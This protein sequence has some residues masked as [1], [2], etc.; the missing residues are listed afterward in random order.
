MSQPIHPMTIHYKFLSAIL[1][2]FT[3]TLFIP[4]AEVL[5]VIALA[6]LFLYVVLNKSV[7]SEF[8]W[9]S[10]PVFF[11]L[12]LAFPAWLLISYILSDNQSDGIRFLEKRIPLLIF[13]LSLGLLTFPKQYLSRILLAVASIVTLACLGALLASLIQYRQTG[14]SAYLYN[15]SLSIH[16]GQQSIYTSL[17]VNCSI[18]IFSW[19]FFFLHP[20][21]RWKGWLGAGIVFLLGI[22]YLLASRNM[23]LMLY[24]SIVL[25]VGYYIVQRRKYLEGITLLLGLLMGAFMIYKF[26]PK[27]LNR[28]REL[29]V[30]SYNYENNA[31]E[32]HYAGRFSAEQ[33]NGANFRLAAWPCGWQLVK[34]HPLMGT[35]IGDKR[36]ELNRVYLQRG[37]RFAIETRKNVHNNYLD[38]LYSTGPIGLLLFL[39]GWCILPLLYFWRRRQ[40]V[41]VFIQSTLILAM[42]TEVYFDRSIG[43]LAL[44]FLTCLLLA[45]SRGVS[46]DIKITDYP[47][48]TSV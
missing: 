25:F 10:Q 3:A 21:P 8:S 17:F 37:F 15:D 38:I 11:W 24:C 13:P 31:G 5:K 40:W 22:S 30:T 27:T 23:M 9:R 35:G 12:M 2:F 44:G 26:F 36:D 1:L 42:V 34:E 45:G 46:P 4:V 29:T 33:W 18:Y 41:A 47:P 39:G 43:A 16:L 32:S 7:R 19:Q 6:I 20:A 48:D 14:D 28:F